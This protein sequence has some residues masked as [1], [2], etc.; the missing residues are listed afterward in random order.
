MSERSEGRV[1]VEEGVV[2]GTGGGRA[3]RCDVYRPPEPRPDGRSVL[4]IHGGAWFQGDRRQLGG[5]GILLG[6]LG[7]TCVAPEYRL[8]GET[9][10]PAQIHDVKACLRFM[11]AESG[12]LGIDPDQIV[13][14]G[15]SAGG[16]LA[17]LLAATPGS[18]AFEGEGGHP[19]MPTHV[20]ACVAFYPPARLTSLHR[21]D[22]EIPAL[23]EPTASNEE[24]DAASPLHYATQAGLPPIL[25]LHG[26][27]DGLV[28]VRGTLDLHAALLRSGAPVEL[29]VFSGAPHG[30]DAERGLGRQSA[31]LAHLFLERLA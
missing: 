15:N 9:R 23:F 21:Q 24:I 14:W 16:H 1:K 31:Q 17:L 25:L 29:H 2:Y 22:G 7:Y 5:Y 20:R 11:R 27:R 13:A 28:P 30:F 19:G 6:R 12:G 8:T 4:L 10:W 3:L 26:D 18:A